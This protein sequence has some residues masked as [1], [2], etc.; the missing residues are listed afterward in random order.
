M[1]KN[2]SPPQGTAGVAVSPW[3]QHSSQLGGGGGQC[4]GLKSDLGG[5][6]Q[7]HCVPGWMLGGGQGREQKGEKR[8]KKDPR[9]Q[10]VQKLWE[11]AVL[12]GNT[13][14]LE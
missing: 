12:S 13:K 6:H 7:L 9:G 10:C 4:T 11:C 5:H 14:I 8:Q 1:A 3:S 2:N